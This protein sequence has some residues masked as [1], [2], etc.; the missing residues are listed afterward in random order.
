MRLNTWYA[1][2]AAL[3]TA[4]LT[5]PVIAGDNVEAPELRFG[6]VAMNIPAEMHQRLKPLTKYL[7]ESLKRPVSLKLSP[8]MG[9][10]IKNLVSNEVELAY[11]TP[12]AYI[13]AHDAGGAKVVV[14]T[15]TQNEGSF[16]LV[17]AVRKDSPIQT[18]ADLAGKTFAF[19]DKAALLQRAAVVGAGMPIEKLGEHK[20][21]GHYD[22]IARGVA[23]GDFDA[24]IL[25]DTIAYKWEQQGLRIIYKSPALPPYNIA[26]SKNLDEATM[27]ALRKAFLALDKNRPEHAEV[28]QALDKDYDGFAP[29]SDAEYDVVRELIKPFNNG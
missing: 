15:I 13:R 20:F 27:A 10:A 4:M 5:G 18:V 11:L 25:K 19:G 8:D 1:A 9:A 28:I 22:N 16:Q 23:N 21:I 29:T 2:T 12:V 3:M 14:K 17:I 26:A 6:S 24:G 7:S